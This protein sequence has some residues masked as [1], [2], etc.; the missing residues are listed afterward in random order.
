[1]H[2]CRAVIVASAT[3]LLNLIPTA[4]LPV[5][6]HAET[7]VARAAQPSIVWT[8]PQ[9]T[10]VEN[11]A[12]RSNG[13][14]LATLF[15]SPQIYQVDPT[16]KSPASLVYTFPQQ[17]SCLGIAEL[18]TD[19]FYVVAGNVSFTTFA[20]LPGSFNVYKIDMT[21]YHPGG[22]PSVSKVANFPQAKQLN[23][24]TVLNALQNT[25]A[26]ADSAAGSVYSLNVKS[27]AVFPI[28]NDPSESPTSTA[29]PIGVNG[30]KIWGNK[31]FFT[32]TDKNAYTSI[33]ITSTGYA[34]GSASSL[35]NITGPDDFQFDSF[36]HAYF[37]G[38]DAIRKSAA[39]GGAVSTFSDSPL[40]GG[41]TACEFGRT[42]SDSTVLYVSTSGGLNQ[43]I[44]G[45]FTN[46][47]K[48]VA[49]P[50]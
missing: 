48:I 33:P 41:S 40:L 35:S 38:E 10:W 21:N 27:G 49:V 17:T 42:L 4:A 45:S 23:G 37:A 16:G 1:M 50:T 47:G 28:G 30:V 3:F 15:T 5:T 7:V 11:L 43:Y 22:K 31:L 19:I 2:L 12:V 6:A 25:L 14:I 39:T 20:G 24:M 46:P 8:F 36:G 32:N 44:T 18:G 13:Q 34:I 29:V 26:I 9:E